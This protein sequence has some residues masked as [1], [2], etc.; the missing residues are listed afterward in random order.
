VEALAAVVGDRSAE[1]QHER[2]F[3]SG[4]APKPL[5]VVAQ[6]A[7]EPYAGSDCG[8]ALV[9]INTR[10][11]KII[12][13]MGAGAQAKNSRRARYRKLKPRPGGSGDGVVEHQRGRIHAAT[14]DL[15]DE[16]GY[17]SLT[18]TGIARAAGVSNRTFYDNFKD[19]EDCFL[20][21]YDLIVR[22]TAREVIAARQ[23]ASSRPAMMRA[24]FQALARE[25]AKKPKAARLALVEAFA[26]PGALGQMR[27]TRGLFEALVADSFGHE[28]G[29]KLPPLI[30]KAIVAGS[31]R[32]ARA[33]LLAGE[34]GRLP[35]DAEELVRWALALQSRVAAEQ[36]CREALG[37]TTKL[38]A[39]LAQP[40]EIDP[41][42]K[43]EELL[44]DERT[45]IVAAAAELAAQEGF[46]ALT[47]PRIR[48]AAGVSRRRFDEYFEDVI[49]CFLAALDLTV[50]RLLAKARGAFLT[51]EAWPNGIYRTIA[52]SCREIA[53]DPALVKLAFVELL[54]PGRE[55]VRWRGE[56][57]RRQSSF[58]RESAP[59]EQRPTELAAEASTAAIW[60]VLYHYAIT[61]R[62]RD[63]TQLPGALAFVFLAPAIGAERAVDVIRSEQGVVAQ[64]R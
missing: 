52:S 58:M 8:P 46:E 23:R 14:I 16:A 17:G 30:V 5:A 54:V 15:V 41:L 12:S 55:T 53:N 57:M 28:D 4:A 26:C 11:G 62:A 6:F 13:G 18:L 3:R 60:A 9:P 29:G 7:G 27:H 42:P 59:T 34:E 51:A 35:D 45:M 64:S 38:P 47:V 56:M 32:I 48:L 24:G 40:G 37:A 49:D 19:K 61:G 36:V 22:H 2:I 50:G 63:L 31:T 1:L 10:I 39:A 25:V 44:V 43:S 20:A 21:T 33:R